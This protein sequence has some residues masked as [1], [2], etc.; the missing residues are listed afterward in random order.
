M[1]KKLVVIGNGMAPGRMR[2]QLRYDDPGFKT[3]DCCQV[4]D[5]CNL[6][7]S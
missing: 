2:E 3:T 4:L 5:Q 6:V 7:A 1:K